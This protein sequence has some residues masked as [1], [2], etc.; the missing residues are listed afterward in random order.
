[1]LRILWLF[2]LYL[3]VNAQLLSDWETITDKNDI[4][5]IVVSEEL[6]WA[7]T[8]GGAFSYHTEYNTVQNYTNLDGLETTELTCVVADNNNNIIFGA[9]DGTIQ[10]YDKLDNNWSYNY[11]LTGNRIND[12]FYTN[13]TLWVAAGGGLAVFFKDDEEY[14]F[15][16]FFYNFPIFIEE[17]RYV[18]AF[19][20]RVWLAT[21][22]G[23]LSAPSNLNKFTI[24]DPVNWTLLNIT[25]NEEYRTV[26]Q[27]KILNHKLW[28]CTAVGLFY[29]TPDGTLHKETKWG[30]YT[31]N[32]ITA[33]DDKYYIINNKRYFSYTP[34][35]GRIAETNFTSL[36]TGITTDTQGNVWTALGKSDMFSRGM[37]QELGGLY[38]NGWPEI[39][40]QDGPGQNDIRFLLR[41][42]NNRI[43]ASSGRPKGTPNLGFYVY[44]GE[45]WINNDYSGSGWSDLGNSNVIYED[46]FGNVWI[47]SWGGGVIV[48]KNDGDTLYF[49]NYA[50]NGI[51]LQ[52]GKDFYKK[53]EIDESKV[54]KGFFSPVSGSSR[55]EVITDIEEDA[56][57]RLWFATYAPSNGNQLT[58]VSYVDDFIDTLHTNA[59]YFNLGSK[60][61]AIISMTFDD[62]GRVW[63]GKFGGGVAVLNYNGTLTNKSDDITST[64]GTGEG[65]YSGPVL[66]LAKDSDGVVWIGTA[67]GLNSYDGQNV[68]K[69]VGDE[70]GRSGPLENQI[71][72]IFV[73]AYN[74]KWFSTPA[75]ISVLGGE[76]SPWDV[77]GW[78][79]YSTKNSNILSDNVQNIFVDNQT[80]EALVGMDKGLQKFKGSF[81][82]ISENYKNVIAGPN[83]FYANGS[84]HLIIKNLKANSAVK[85]FSLSGNLIQKL[86]SGNGMFQG[87]RAVWDGKNSSG[88][89]VASG[90]YLFTAWD[91]NGKSKSGK[92][93]LI[94]K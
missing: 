26:N 69:H 52:S 58:V 47:G 13:D 2:F 88:K 49:H 11:S 70:F 17:A 15:K 12:I 51:L 60:A 83:P 71:N 89:L 66:S 9:E 74:N 81:A 8:S 19:A 57:G 10:F 54:V 84:N 68:Y 20:D 44:D 29:I 72:S 28:V 86:N 21:E 18:A 5:G 25:G 75:G 91:E 80:R 85:I 61:S 46:R 43:W 94:R 35:D 23:L 1:M 42:R 53:I 67:S 45:E 27:F 59:T 16:D 14:R 92:I 22:Q 73:D 39:F 37:G 48:F 30:N 56:Y 33:F 64:I 79:G 65:L 41:D 38:K 62:F 40:K 32:Y 63:L 77:N 78:V 55:Y 76:K 90:V 87:S 4:M 7:A 36:P 3:S 34:E 82:E 31:S 93:A 24:N 6:I 50:G